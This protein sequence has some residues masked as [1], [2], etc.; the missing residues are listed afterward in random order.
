MNSATSF[1]IRVG[2]MG[3]VWRFRNPKAISLCRGD[4]VVCRTGRGVEIGSVV[5]IAADPESFGLGQSGTTQVGTVLRRAT[6]EDELLETRLGKFKRQAVLECRSE[7]L[8]RGISATLLDVDHL[9]DGRTLIFHFLGEVDATLQAITDRLV[10]AYERRTK[11]KHF[12]QLLA[13]GCGPGCG[14]SSA[15]GCSTSGG[16]AV[17]VIA[18][19]C[20]KK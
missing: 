5:S 2:S 6:G 12:A 7:I 13:E 16:C 1:H 19:S 18:A 9:F 15:E 17:C 10:D 4:R 8:Q 20:G 3:E 14:T 11:L